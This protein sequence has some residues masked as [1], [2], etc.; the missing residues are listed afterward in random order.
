MS[1]LGLKIFIITITLIIASTAFF[2]VTLTEQN[3][4]ISKLEKDRDYYSSLYENSVNHN[5]D[6]EEQITNIRAQNFKTMAEAKTTYEKLLKD[7]PQLIAQK[8]RTEV[9]S[10]PSQVS[11]TVN[12][13][14]PVSKPKTSS[15]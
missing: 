9:K 5:R 4:K 11:T 10:V 8:T 1:K 6:Y 7:Q 2:F 13:S 15:S 12:V 3:K 14:K